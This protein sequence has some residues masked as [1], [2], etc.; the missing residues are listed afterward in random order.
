M[1]ELQFRKRPINGTL[2]FLFSG[3]CLY[4]GYTVSDY[5]EA[6]NASNTAAGL[7]GI[8]ED[9]Y[10][11]GV[12]QVLSLSCYIL[13]A[14]CLIAGYLLLSGASRFRKFIGGMILV[15]TFIL[16]L[17]FGLSGAMVSFYE[18]YRAES[19][20]STLSS[21]KIGAV[22][23]IPFLMGLIP[24][25]VLTISRPVSLAS[26]SPQTRSRTHKCG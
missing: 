3:L 22:V 25:F 17:F 5:L 20:A 24:S 11:S 7:S 19:W 26:S 23:I 21:L 6:L 13:A 15:I 9:A 12:S 18:V 16:F 4:L 8:E 10:F 14:A 2:M 1:A